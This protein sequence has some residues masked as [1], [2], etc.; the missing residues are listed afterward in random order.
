M[1]REL[2]G[3]AG[4]DVEVETNGGRLVGFFANV[5]DESLLSSVT[6]QADPAGMTK[7]SYSFSEETYLSA[8]QLDPMTAGIPFD[9]IDS[10]DTIIA[11]W[12][13]GAFDFQID[14]PWS[15]SGTVDLGLPEGTSL[16]IRTASNDTKTWLEGGTATVGPNNALSSDADS[17]INQ[18]TTLVL[19]LEAGD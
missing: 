1:L 5:V 7:G 11:L 8:V 15:F 4:L 12:Y 16:S 19:V 9:G 17:G 6:V 3:A 14:P 18:L 2:P 10:A 13:L